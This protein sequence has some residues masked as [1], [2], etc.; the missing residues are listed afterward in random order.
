MDGWMDGWTY[1]WM[2]GWMDGFWVY[3]WDAR[4]SEAC[5][6]LG[7]GLGCRYGLPGRTVNLADLQPGNPTPT[8]NRCSLK[9]C[10][11]PHA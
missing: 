4:L 6:R 5:H 3:E 11:C 2:H 9:P 1:G 7:W 10:A 8:S